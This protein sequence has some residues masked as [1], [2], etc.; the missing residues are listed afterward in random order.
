MRKRRIFLFGGQGGS[1]AAMS[2]SIATP[3][4]TVLP[5]MPSGRQF[6]AAAA[7]IVGEPTHLISPL[8]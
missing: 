7:I 5:P 4:W 8:W 1:Y 3:Q 2:Y 6:A